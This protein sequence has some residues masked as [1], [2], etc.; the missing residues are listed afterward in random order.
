VGQ[1]PCLWQRSYAK[2]TWGNALKILKYE[3]TETNSCGGTT[4]RTK[5]EFKKEH[6]LKSQSTETETEATGPFAAPGATDEIY[7]LYCIRFG[8]PWR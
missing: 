3:C 6:W 8:S 2:V 1:P 4:K 5:F 7:E